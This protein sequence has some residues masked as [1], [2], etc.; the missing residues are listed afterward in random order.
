MLTY[1]RKSLP[2]MEPE[3]SLL[4]SYGPATGHYESRVLSSD[5]QQTARHYIPEE[6]TLHDHCHKN[7]K[8]YTMNPVHTLHPTFLGPILIL[9]SIH[10]LVFQVCIEV[11][12]P[13]FCMHFPYLQCKLH[14]LPISSSLFN[15]HI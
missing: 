5:F 15:L 1:S 8:S 3:G 2:S 14:A 10:A 4:C 13:K 6:I 9:S 12:R 11:L 7:L